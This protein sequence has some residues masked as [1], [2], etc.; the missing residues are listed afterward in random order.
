MYAA[1]LVGVL[2]GITGFFSIADKIAT[3]R[4]DLTRLERDFINEQ[5]L[6]LQSDV[7]TLISRIES[8][9]ELLLHQ[10]EQELANRVDEAEKIAV[11]ISSSIRTGLSRL[12]SWTLYGKPFVP[13]GSTT[14]RGTVSSLTGKVM[15]FSTRQSRALRGLIFSPTI[16]ATVPRLRVR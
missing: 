14:N 15:R 11:N 5:K 16:L 9:Q 2:T 12:L 6:Q 8:Q 13:F 1:I 7:G 4:S 10:L 3:L